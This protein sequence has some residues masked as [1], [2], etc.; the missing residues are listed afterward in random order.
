VTR[1]RVAPAW[2][3]PAGFYAI[4]CRWP[5]AT[6]AGASAHCGTCGAEGRLPLPRDPRYSAAVTAFLESHKHSEAA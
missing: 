4:D 1:A 2:R 6:I 3:T 5:W